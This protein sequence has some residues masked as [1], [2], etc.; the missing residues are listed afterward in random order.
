[1]NHSIEKIHE[2]IFKHADYNDTLSEKIVQ[3]FAACLLWPGWAISPLLDSCLPR[4]VMALSFLIGRLLLF[5]SVGIGGTAFADPLPAHAAI[6]QRLGALMTDPSLRRTEFGVQVVNVNT[7]EEVFARNADKELIPASLVKVLTAAVALRELGSG[8]KFSTYLS[9]DGKVDADGTL[10]G[11]L[12]V[13][14]FGDP[15]LVTEDVWRLVYDLWLAGV[16]R[17]DGDV[18]YDDSH[19]DADRLIAGWRKDVDIANGPAYFAP[20]GA[21][22]VNFNTVAVV[23]GPG[24]EVGGPAGV[25]LETPSDSVRLINEVKTGAV[26]TR[27]RYSVERTVR[28]RSQVTLKVKGSVPMGGGPSRVYRTIVDPLA[29]FQSVFQSHLNDRGIEVEGGHRRD[30]APD[31]LKMLARKESA[32]LPVVLARMNKHS[33]NLFAEHVLK[34]VGAEVYG[35]PGTTEKGLRV[36]AEYLEELGAHAS[37]FEVVNGSGLTRLSRLRPSHIN[38]V[39]LDMAADRVLGPEFTSSLSIGGVDG[40]L[41]T[42]FRGEGTEGRLRGKTGSLNFVHGLTAY[43]D[44]GDGEQYAFTFMVN[45]IGGSNRPVRR[46]H[47]R[48]GQALMDL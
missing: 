1:M 39:M 46:L 12:Y 45:E 6:E 2:N 25:V 26:N 47:S 17:I 30:E 20:L 18:I 33:S 16:R 10:T 35:E 36:V 24:P 31:G 3:P 11:D 15:S 44:G 23:I 7:G 38:A 22:S 19:F 40:T 43:V 5:T 32:S 27:T 37:E 21:L 28:G 14:G 41:W 13:Q 42:R 48:F 4:F 34:A 29:Q 9:A 8:Y